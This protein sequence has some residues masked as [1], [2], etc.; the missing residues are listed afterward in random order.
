MKLFSLEELRWFPA[1]PPLLR[2]AW[3]R[4]LL[5]ALLLFDIANYGFTVF[6]DAEVVGRGR[7]PG[8]WRPIFLFELF[9]L[10]PA[11]PETVRIVHALLLGAALAML[12]GLWTRIATALAAVLNVYWTGLAYAYTQPHHDKVAF[13][14]ALFCLALGPS[15]RRLSLDAVRAR[16]RAA[17]RGG[18]P[19]AA[20]LTHP[21][22][23]FPVQWIR[24]T[25]ALGYCAPGWSK[26]VIAGPDWANGYTLMG[27]LMGHH[28]PLADWFAGDLAL[29]RVA[30]VVT[31]FLQASFPIV[32]IAPALRWVYLPGVTFFHMMTWATMDT[33][34]YITL[35]LVLAA[36]LPLERTAL[37]ARGWL[38]ARG[39]TRK[40]LLKRVGWIGFFVLLPALVLWIF[41]RALSPW[42]L[43]LAL[44]ALHALVSRAFMTRLD[45]IWDGQCGICRR[46][47][48]VLAALDF[49]LGLRFLDFRRFAPV[50]RRHPSLTP[51]ACEHDLHLV[52]AR[53][54]VLRGFE[55]Y[56]RIA[57]RLPLCL[58]LVP[59][60]HLP[61]VAAIGRRVYRFVADHRRRSAC[62]LPAATPRARPSPRP[63]AADGDRNP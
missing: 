41:L 20:P 44:P 17:R 1:K 49:G 9:G 60:L 40:R 32:L 13:S 30:A 26:L 31:L 27:I 3:L 16:W 63:P 19:L 23:A 47:A 7:L 37:Y 36:F 54:R 38:R 21:H 43:L 5:A 48:A 8:P 15:G 57:R 58:P 56:R 53:G 35:W 10:G 2:L 51:E 50:A 33:G 18:D 55:A 52:D 22:A 11:G 25:L 12:T 6:A 61:P 24:W 42:W 59:F 14:L 34:P 62:G 28:G 39:P 45:V 4:I 46:A 29:L